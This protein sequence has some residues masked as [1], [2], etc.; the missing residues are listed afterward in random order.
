[1]QIWKCDFCK[2]ELKKNEVFKK[3]FWYIN[4][5]LELCSDCLDIY[6]NAENEIGVT[7]NKIKQ[8]ANQ[9]IEENIKNILKKYKID[10]E[11]EEDE[12][13]II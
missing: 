2:K 11:E 12:K 5:R 3:D 6:N 7:N 10:V 13:E 8:E 9:K 1:M 4:K